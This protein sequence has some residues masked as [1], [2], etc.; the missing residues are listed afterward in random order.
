MLNFFFN[1]FDLKKYYNP[2]DV[3]FPY[4]I[5]LGYLDRIDAW[6]Y[7]AYASLGKNENY[8]SPT[9]ALYYLFLIGIK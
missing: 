8:T 2:G 3:L 4:N 5:D 6:N 1:I 7:A 9:I